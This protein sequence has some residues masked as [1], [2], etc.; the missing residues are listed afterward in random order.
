MSDILF[1]RHAETG[2]AGTFCGHSDPPLNSR[3][4]QQVRDLIASL[5]PLSID[6]IHCSD[7]QR[8]TD[9]AQ[10]IADAFNIPVHP[11]PALREIHFGDWEGLTWAEIEE[12]DPAFARAWIDDFPHLPAPGGETFAAFHARVLAEIRRI[13]ILAEHSRIAVV[14]HAGVLRVVLRTL[15]GCNETE[16]W[17]RTKSYC[18]NFPYSPTAALQELAQ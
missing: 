17:N 2:L 8:A 15:Q 14:T 5:A 10:V 4:E 1:I 7:L 18:A 3:G 12:R 11:T 13:E 6:C 16:A 9:T